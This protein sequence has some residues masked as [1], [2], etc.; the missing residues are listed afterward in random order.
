MKRGSNWF[1]LA[2]AGLAGFYLITTLLTNPAALFQQAAII[3]ITVA[4]IYLVFRYVM[5]KRMG[6]D[7]SSYSKAAKHT[8]RSAYEKT[9]TG[10]P[11][12]TVTPIKK[13]AKTKSF[14]KK[15]SSHLT[16]IEGKKGKKKNRAL[17]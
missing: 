2:I 17:F 9:H 12:K 15:N 5:R 8:K 4:I 7:Y 13:Y 1:F 14:K 16:V 6:L 3:A 10:S 11:S